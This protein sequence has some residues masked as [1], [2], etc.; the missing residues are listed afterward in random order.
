MCVVISTAPLGF[1]VGAP[2][3][4]IDSSGVFLREGGVRL[5]VAAGPP[6]HRV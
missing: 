1:V 6:S 4:P 3:V 5:E 2:A